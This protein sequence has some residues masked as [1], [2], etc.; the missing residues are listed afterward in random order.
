MKAASRWLRPACLAA[1]ITLLAGACSSNGSTSS[2]RRDANRIVVG[3]F[4]FP[5][6]ELLAE[7]YAQAMVA[8]GYPVSLLLGIGTRELVEP[9]LARG[10]VQFAPEY[11]GSALNFVSLG[12]GGTS[13]DPEATHLALDRAL[14][15]L[16]LRA[17]SASPAQ[18]A[19]G[20]VV[21]RET[22]E[23][24]GL[25]S[26]SDLARDASNLV[27]GGPQECPQ[28]PF[29]LV[30]LGRTYGLR[31]GD[32]VPL[33]TG[34]PLTLSALRAGKV[35]VALLFTTDPAIEVDHLVLLQDDRDLQPAENVTPVVRAEVVA[36]FGRPF[37]DLIDSVSALLSTDGLRELNAR[38][39]SRGETAAAAARLWLQGEGLA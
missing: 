10:L 23:R 25:Q 13:S 38:M 2:P 27:F 26:V 17:L 33:D 37:V 16:G 20:I 19:N 32:F 29:C 31:F 9:S 21:T 34:G 1:A 7:I 6:S 12:G 15:P 24:Y 39:S 5:E 3:S 28:R 36:R 18:D 30:G 11:S 14:G 22:A 4:D 8:H 35:D